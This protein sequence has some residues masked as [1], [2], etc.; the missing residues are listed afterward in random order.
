MILKGHTS[1]FIRKERLSPTSEAR[2]EASR[3]EFVEKGGM[4][5]RDKSFREIDSRQD[6]PRARPAFVKPV[7][8]GLRKVQNL[9]E[10]RPSRAEIDLAGRENGMRFQ[11]EEKTRQN[12]AYKQ[13]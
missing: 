8:N 10:C 7:R 9:I 2:R 12:D 3:N 11:K 1:V 5:D 6:R 13:L 4:P